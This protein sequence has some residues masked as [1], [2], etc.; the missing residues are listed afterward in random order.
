MSLNVVFKPWPNIGIQILTLSN[1]QT[2]HL[3]SLYRHK[4]YKK[5]FEPNT[6]NKKISA[7]LSIV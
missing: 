5:N 1:L 2:L 7:N 4:I 3:S 6:R